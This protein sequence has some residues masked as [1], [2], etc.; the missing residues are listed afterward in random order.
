[1]KSIF[2]KLFAV[3]TLT[4]FVFSFAACS[5]N[6]E[7]TNDEKAPSSQSS[8]EPAPSK[9]QGTENKNT[10]EDGTK[11]GDANIYEKDGKP[12]AKTESGQEV[13]ISGDN[14]NELIKEYENVKGSG[15]AKEKEILDKIQLILEAPKN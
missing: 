5:K 13:E 7:K 8:S 15:S 4:F 1:M 3:L 2:L 6:K 10:N 9:T 11:Y 12:H 14:L